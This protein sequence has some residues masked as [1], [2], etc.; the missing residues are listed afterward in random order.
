MDSIFLKDFDTILNQILVD[1]RAQIPEADTSKGTILYIRA[2]CTASMGWGIHRYQAWISDQIFP[3]TSD[4][5]N[6]EHH[7]YINGIDRKDGETIAALL[8]RDLD[9]RR[10]P[11]AGGNQYDYEKW[12]RE[13][14][15]VADAWSIPLG[16]GPGSVDVV[17][18]ADNETGVP[19]AELILAVTEYIDD[20]RPA[21]MRYLRVMAPEDL[22][23]DITLTFEGDVTADT[24]EADVESYLT[25][26][27][28]GQDLVLSQ[29]AKAIMTGNDLDDITVTVPAA[30]VTVTDYQRITAGTINVTKL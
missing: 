23:T 19:D 25:R 1:Y 15:G 17:I 21:G 12:A 7:A 11:P 8:A 16:Q 24:V 28:P 20:L 5:E 10:K 18:A 30:N 9:D 2:C 29:L 26:Q 4:D 27:E 14:E 3:D 6:V 13:V 22:A